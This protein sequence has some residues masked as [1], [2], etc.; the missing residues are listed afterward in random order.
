MLPIHESEMP[1]VKDSLKTKANH[2]CQGL[3]PSQ[4][5]AVSEEGRLCVRAESCMVHAAPSAKVT[6][7]GH[8]LFRRLVSFS[9]YLLPFPGNFP[10]CVHLLK[11]E[12]K[13]IPLQESKLDLGNLAAY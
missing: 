8:G 4:M 1:R 5:V 2:L 10:F 7:S 12:G 13:K 11:E 6:C 3:E 9:L